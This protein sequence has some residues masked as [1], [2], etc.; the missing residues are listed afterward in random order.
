MKLPQIKFPR[1][2]RIHGGEFDGS[3]RAIHRSGEKGPLMTYEKALIS[4]AELRIVRGSTNERKQMST[5]TLRKRIALVAVSALGF[6]LVSTVPA[7]A[8]ARTASAGTS[9]TVQAGVSSTLTTLTLSAPLAAATPD[10]I[11]VAS[12]TGPAGGAITITDIGGS[13]IVTTAAANVNTVGQASHSLTAG[14][15]DSTTGVVTGSVNMPGVYVMTIG[16]T[17]VTINVVAGTSTTT[18]LTAVTGNSGGY[19]VGT[20]PVITVNRNTG[21]AL[22]DGTILARVDVTPDTGVTVGQILGES[23]ET[24]VTPSNSSAS[25]VFTFANGTFDTA[26]TYSFTFWNDTNANNALDSGEVTT[27]GSFTVGAASAS[28]SLVSASLSRTLGSSTTGLSAVTVTATITDA[29]GNPITGTVYAAE[30]T[31]TGAA[32][33]A[34]SNAGYTNVS[35]SIGASGS[36]LTRVGTTN[37][38]VGTFAIDVA[39]TAADY[40]DTYITVYTDNIAATATTSAKK[41]LRIANDTALMTTVSGAKAIKLNQSATDTPVGTVSAGVRQTLDAA[42]A[43][44]AAAVTATV[45]KTYVS[46]VY[47]INGAS[48]QEGEYLRVSV[49]P[50]A[51]TSSTV[52]APTSYLVVMGADLTATITVAATAPAAGDGYVLTVADGTN[53]VTSTIT[54]ATAAPAWTVSP[55]ANIKAKYGDKSAVTGTLADQFGRVLASKA[56]SVVVAGRNAGTVLGTTDAA[57]AFKFEWTDASTSTVVLT[58]SLVFNYA[59]TASSTS[60][61]TT[62][63]SSSARTV[64]YSATGIEVGSITVTAPSDTTER[65]VDQKQ[66][67][68][69]AASTSRVNFTATIKTAAGA[70]VGAGLLVTFA[71]S[72]ADLFYGGVTTAV[73]DEFGQA[74]VTVYRKLVGTSAITATAGGLTATAAGVKW[75]NKLIGTASPYTAGSSADYTARYITLTADKT[76]AVSEGIIRFTAKVTDRFGNAVDGVDVTFSETGAGRFYNAPTSNTAATNS[77]GEVSIDIKSDAGET[78]AVSVTA[79][80]TDANAVQKDDIA[81]YMSYAD[82]TSGTANAAVTTAVSGLT[83]AVKSATATATISAST[84]TSTAD[85]LL[86][87]AQALGTRDQASA[88]ID[89]AA[90]ATDAANAAT[91]AANAAAEAADAATAA[92]QDASD[93]VATLSAQV[94]EAIAGLK[95]QLVSLTNLVIK[96]QKKVKA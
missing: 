52:V 43:S 23:T 28:T 54:F 59:Y 65:A 39:Y 88:T 11:V 32:V 44:A 89:A 1:R 80:I 67:S 82:H 4:Q 24:V 55:S 31:S 50:A 47:T 6:G 15:A 30:T 53:S 93:A 33:S 92:A 86:A 72:S 69:G 49:A 51:A 94:S 40:I 70:P 7:F 26:G 25:R 83:A 90:E 64:T 74:T 87:L 77:S 12:T 41:A 27:T 48:G 36:A 42:I 78:G 17:A 35:G 16:G 14:T 91:D 63:A 85:A 18:T 3:A 21:G 5:K 73:T 58:D 38:Y 9:T 8:L 45:D 10:T 79:A 76:A 71:G 60:T 2:V 68:S 34:N 37:T 81:G 19:V 96:I 62:T 84:A 57:G 29:D 46:H 20:D 66:G 95:K 13:T 22:T 75:S 56:V 61:S